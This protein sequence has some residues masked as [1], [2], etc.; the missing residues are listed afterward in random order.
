MKTLATG[1]FGLALL[2]AT[3]AFAQQ[4][5]HSKMDH[6][7]MD[8]AAPAAKA[9]PARDARAPAA[10]TAIEH[11]QMDHS[12]MGHDMSGMH[13]M[14]MPRADGRPATPV[15]PPTD[16]D[17]AAAVPPAGGHAMHGTTRQYYVLFNRLEG[18]DAGTGSGQA[19]EAHGW[20]GGDRS[21]L[22]L[23][24]E[25]ER[26][27]GH[28]ESADLEVLYGRAFARWWEV[29]AG[30]RHD[31]KPGAAQDFV[32]VGVQG[33]APYKFEV[34]ATAYLGRSGQAGA[35]LEVEYETRLSDRWILQP[36][37]ELEFHGKDDARRGIGSGLGTAEA[38]A[39]L[40]CEVTRQ[41]APYIGIVHERAFGRTSGMR[42][43]AGEEVR[44]TRLVAGLRFWF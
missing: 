20:V 3:P 29:V 18:F 10:Q 13:G 8:R 44:D 32:A 19:W 16:A 36:L 24:S 40:R 28:A 34:A 5:D 41:F 35:R 12:S 39:R 38:G 6:S 42:R 11:A 31:F 17:R 1:L 22:W 33:L 43:A 25:G 37:L 21:K 4:A 30:V 27:G 9:E 15:P 7:K 23:R 14:A 26:S 2:S